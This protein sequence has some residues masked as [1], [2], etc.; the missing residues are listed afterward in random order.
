MTLKDD[1]EGIIPLSKEM[2]EQL[3]IW[4]NNINLKIDLAKEIEEKI[5]LLQVL[6]S[7]IYRALDYIEEAI[8]NN[9]IEKVDWEFDECVFSDMPAERIKPLIDILKGE[10]KQ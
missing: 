2:E 9:K 7:R 10:N 8:L 1:K 4:Y 3:S 5:E 6:Q